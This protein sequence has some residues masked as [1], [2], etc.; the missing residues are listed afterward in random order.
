MKI[1]LVQFMYLWGSLLSSWSSGWHMKLRICRKE[2]SALMN[3][4]NRLLGGLLVF[5]LADRWVRHS[6]SGDSF[7]YME[8]CVSPENRDEVG[9]SFKT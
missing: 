8:G 2:F 4:L 9:F 7:D 1:V 5:S 6:P 3:L